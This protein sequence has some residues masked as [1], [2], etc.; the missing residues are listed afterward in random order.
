[1]KS[2]G[3]TLT[4]L[5]GV[6]AILAIITIIAFPNIMNSIKRSESKMTNSQ[7]ELIYSS[8]DL[9]LDN[10]QSIYNFTYGDMYSIRIQTLVD[11]DLLE[12][13]FVDS[14]DELDANTCV[15]VT[16]IDNNKN[17]TKAIVECE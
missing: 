12:Q 3:F 15:N 9:Y 1:M 4:E 2:R 6:I 17:T 13:A 8:V 10:H 16:I 11:E 5:L 14:I 7:K